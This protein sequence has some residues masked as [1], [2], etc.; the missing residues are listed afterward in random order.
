M[1]YKPSDADVE[2][3][4][5]MQS[6]DSR[7]SF[8]DKANSLAFDLIGDDEDGLKRRKSALT[9]DSKKHKFVRPTVGSDNKKMIRTD[10]GALIP[11]T[12]KSKRYFLSLKNTVINYPHICSIDTEATELR[13]IK[14]NDFNFLKLFRN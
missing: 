2:R 13:D 4:Y 5:T 11:A 12:F 9:W 7:T 14:V 3:G 8:L 1:S 6:S 10:S